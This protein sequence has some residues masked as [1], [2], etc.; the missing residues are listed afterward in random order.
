MVGYWTNP[1]PLLSPVDL[2]RIIFT[3]SM[4]PYRENTSIN[5]S[6]QGD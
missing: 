5:V 2:S 6:L 4:L 3:E 1:I